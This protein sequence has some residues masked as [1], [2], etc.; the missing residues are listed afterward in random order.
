MGLGQAFLAAGVAC[1]VVSLHDLN[2]Q[3]SQQIMRAFYADLGA[4]NMDVEHTFDVARAL[5]KAVRQVSFGG[6]PGVV[7]GEGKRRKGKG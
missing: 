1:V 2:D 3:L 5:S 6:L 4:G 7:S